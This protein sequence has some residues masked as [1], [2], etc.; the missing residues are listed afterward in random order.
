MVVGLEPSFAPKRANVRQKWSVEKLMEVLALKFATQSKSVRRAFRAVAVA[1][2]D[3]IGNEQMRKWLKALNLGVGAK[4]GRKLFETIDKD[5]SGR[6]S[7]EEFRQAFGDQISGAA[8]QHSFAPTGQRPAVRTAE[9]KSTSVDE[10]VKLLRERMHLQH[11]KVREAFRL[12]DKD[13]SGVLDRNEFERMLEGY[14]MKLEEKDLDEL[15]ERVSGA[16]GGVSYR[17]FSRFFGSDIAGESFKNATLMELDDNR[18]K[19]RTAPTGSKTWTTSEFLSTLETVLRSRSTTVRRIFR[20]VDAD[21]SG[22][23]DE[24]EFYDALLKLN[25][26]MP[27][28]HARR[29]FALFDEDGSGAISYAELTEKIGG[30]VA[31]YRDTGVLTMK[32]VD[33]ADE[34]TRTSLSRHIESRATKVP[35]PPRFTI[36][37][38]KELIARRMGHK[39]RSACAAFRQIDQNHLGKISTDNFRHFLQNRNIELHEDDFQNFVA[40]IDKDGDDEI[41]YQEFLRSFGEAICGTPWENKTT[42]LPTTDQPSPVREA[43][44]AVLPPDVALDLLHR[45]LTE[46]STSVN[47]LFK[48]YNKDRAGRLDNDQVDLMFQN[49]NLATDAQ[50]VVELVNSKHGDD[51]MTYRVFALEFGPSIAGH[52]YQGIVD[53]FV[54]EPPKYT[55]LAPPVVDAAKAKAMLLSKLAQNFGKGRQAFNTFNTLRDGALDM[56]ELRKALANYHIYLTDAEFTTFA[57]EFDPTGSGSVDFDAFLT[58]VGTQI[59]GDKDTGLSFLLQDRDDELRSKRKAFEAAFQE[60]DADSDDSDD[61]AHTPAPQ[62]PQQDQ[63]QAVDDDRLP[64]VRV[65]DAV[66]LPPPRKKALKKPR[67]ARLVAAARRRLEALERARTLTKTRWDACKDDLDIPRAAT[68]ST[69][70]HSASTPR[71]V[72][73]KQ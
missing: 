29:F 27:R 21:Q 11:T 25:I 65:P 10:C 56:D 39:Y 36:P 32:G 3:G 50:K 62:Q 12:F 44:L 52:R 26:V 33:R 13:H 61:D 8:Y 60:I 54:S 71:I 28:D 73:H 2:E 16:P 45:K 20:L 14:N 64:D 41:D 55:P 34:A 18:R 17:A 4:L 69:M 68:T 58:N 66:V 48:R 7:Y 19:P 38:I 30:I 37:Q 49:Y 67:P 63:E 42:S 1:G 6:I 23:I 43:P 9:L 5:G 40:H 22:Y 72:T 35:P 31:G 70:R 59:C 24:D 47:K 15:V 51:G 57:K 53:P 46:S